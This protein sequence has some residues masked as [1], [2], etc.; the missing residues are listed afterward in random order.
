M[1]KELLDTI[2]KTDFSQKE[3]IRLLN[4]L[5][6]HINSF[7]IEDVIVRTKD[8]VTLANGRNLSPEEVIKFKQE[9][10]ALRDN[11][12]FKLFGD[13][14]LFEAIKYGIHFGDTPEKVMF[15]KTAIW[16]IQKFREYIKTFDL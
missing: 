11:W 3:T 4:I 14:I 16:F 5:N 12:A 13:Q 2:E 9:L 1:N 7:P 10:S 6:K 8:G 15:S